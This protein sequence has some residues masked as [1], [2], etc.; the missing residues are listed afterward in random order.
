M[1]SPHSAAKRHP[2]KKAF[3]MTI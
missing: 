1:V 3:T 2:L